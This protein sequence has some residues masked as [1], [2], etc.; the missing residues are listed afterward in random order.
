MGIDWLGPVSVDNDE[1][2]VTVNELP[3]YLSEEEIQN[4]N[5]CETTYRQKSMYLQRRACFIA[6]YIV[7][8]EYIHHLSGINKRKRIIIELQTSCCLH[9]N[10]NLILLMFSNDKINIKGST[11]Q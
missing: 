6:L 11:Q 4:N 2:N 5:Y 7:A 10:Y 1:D 9:N 8:K 3:N